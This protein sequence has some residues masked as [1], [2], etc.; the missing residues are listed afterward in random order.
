MRRQRTALIYLVILISL[1]TVQRTAIAQQRGG[2]PMPSPPRGHDTNPF[3]LSISV[4]DSN[5][6]AVTGLDHSAFTIH[7]GEIQQAIA[8]FSSA[9]VPASI[10]ILLDMSGTIPQVVS[11]QKEVSAR[12]L[13][14]ALLSRLVHYGSEAN[15]YFM[16]AFNKNLKVLLENT[17]G[18]AAAGALDQLDS[19]KFEGPTALYDACYIGIEKANRST[20]QK[21]ALVVI[22]D[23]QD[24]ASRYSEKEV[25]RFLRESNV[26]VYIIAISDWRDGTRALANRDTLNNLALVTGGRALFP[27]KAEEMSDS[28]ERIALE[29]RHQVTIGIKTKTSTKDDKWQPMKV[30]VKAPRNSSSLNLLSRQVYFVYVTRSRN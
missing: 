26:L 6:N 16:I 7:L 24:G 10:G 19:L 5:G 23:G 25:L 15:E 1:F 28:F 2:A 12:S 4:T 21:R 11:P 8:S 17:G 30:K 14:Q 27:S 18:E 22:T 20:H 29:L 13:A 3:L 9:N